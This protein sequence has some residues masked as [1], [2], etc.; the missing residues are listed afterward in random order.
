MGCLESY[1]PPSFVPV[2]RFR[3]SSGLHLTEHDSSSHQAGVQTSCNVSGAQAES[4]LI[5]GVHV[6]ST[7]KLKSYL[8]G[9]LSM[10]SCMGRCPHNT[11]HRQHQIYSHSALRNSQDTVCNAISSLYRT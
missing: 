1:A 5:Y 9:A 2:P 4:R 7:L 11:K 8:L 10:Q 3:R 6:Q